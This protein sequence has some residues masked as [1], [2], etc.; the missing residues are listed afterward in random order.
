[1]ITFTKSARARLA[2]FSAE[3]P[4]LIRKL[5]PILSA[6]DRMRSVNLVMFALHASKSKLRFRWG[7]SVESNGVESLFCALA[8]G[9]LIIWLY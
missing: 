7:A 6:M 8:M 2:A 3:A 9:G 1:M 4:K 5:S